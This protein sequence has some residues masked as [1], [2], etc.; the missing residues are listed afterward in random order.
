MTSERIFNLKDEI[1]SL[2]SAKKHSWQDGD[3]VEEGDPY[4]KGDEENYGHVKLISN[5]NTIN[6]NDE[7]KSAG[8]SIAGMKS[9]IE[10]EIPYIVKNFD[11]IQHPIYRFTSYGESGAVEYGDGTVQVTGDSEEGYIPV[12]V[13]TN[14]FD[15]S[16]VDDIFYVPEN[17]EPDDDRLYQLKIKNNNTYEDVDIWVK[18]Y[19]DKIIGNLDNT[20]LTK[21]ISEELINQLINE[22]KED[23]TTDDI[24]NNDETL[25]SKLENIDQQIRDNNRKNNIDLTSPTETTVN[26]DTLTTPGYYYYNE[27]ESVSQLSYNNNIVHYTNSLII[28]EQQPNGTILQ[29]IYSTTHDNT[30][31][32]YL[33]DGKKYLRIKKPNKEWSNLSL[34]YTPTTQIFNIGA[35]NSEITVKEVTA[36]FIINWTQTTENNTYTI[37]QDKLYEYQIIGQFSPNLPIGN[38]PYIFSSLI[39]K[40]DVKITKANIAVRSTSTTV[41]NVNTSFFVPRVEPLME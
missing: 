35:E 28:V 32:T 12:K 10:K 36:G 25:T 18:I 39:G 21:K 17:T 26:I 9:Y 20:L 11:Q 22:A 34:I 7:N 15:N 33:M 8:V 31:S 6:A 23:L 38:N 41:K 13:L 16:F 5:I 4:G 3:F 40:V 27:E 37:D 29:Y 30:L 1:L 19:Y 24:K 14:E 2:A